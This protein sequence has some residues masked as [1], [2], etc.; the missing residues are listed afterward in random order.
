MS[1][2]SCPECGAKVTVWADI[3][4]VIEFD[5]AKSGKLTKQRIEN[6]N[7]SDGRCGVKCSECGWSLD[8]DDMDE[9]SP[10]LTPAEEA[11][12]K[13][14]KIKSLSAKRE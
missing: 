9:K 5:I 3:D 4:A 2:Y 8:L 14:Q 10:F 11:L 1:K 7:Q 12:D 13:Q 6:S